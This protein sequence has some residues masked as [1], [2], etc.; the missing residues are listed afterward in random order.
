MERTL[1]IT[2]DDGYD[3]K[4]IQV[5]CEALSGLGEIFVAAPA[6]EQSASSHSLTVRKRVCTEKVKE[7][8]YKV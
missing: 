4:G 5:L 2:N 7:G 1:F 3:A 8:H 6:H